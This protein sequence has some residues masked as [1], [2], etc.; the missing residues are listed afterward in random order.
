MARRRPSPRS[1]QHAAGRA[2]PAVRAWPARH[3]AAVC[4]AGLLLAG[5]QPAPSRQSAA[6]DEEP[7]VHIV[8]T[9]EGHEVPDSIMAGLRHV[10]FENRGTRI[11]EAMLVRLPAGMTAMDYAAAVAGG[12][13]FPKGAIDCSGPGLTSPGEALDLWVALEPGRYIVVCWMAHPGERGAF[14]QHVTQA[15]PREFVVR[16]RV[17][18]DPEPAADATLR[19]VDYRFEL[20]GEIE[21]GT[22]TLRVDMLG[23]SMHEMDWYRLHDGSGLQDLK[24]WQARGRKV[25]PPA[26]A[27]GGVL[28][29]H[30]IGRTV[31]VRRRFAPGRYVAWCGMDMPGQAGAKAVTHADMGMVLEFAVAEP[32]SGGGRR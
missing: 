21:A 25:P 20:D 30:D 6:P 16:D 13:P 9:D 27:L 12:E 17:V 18:N 28:D 4:L 22:R 19:M 5:C 7:S 8:A 15:P 3:R 10:R 2:W 31:W 32:R 11:H 26:T 23:P 29:S 24:A 1:F 14:E